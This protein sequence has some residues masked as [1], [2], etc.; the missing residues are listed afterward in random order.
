M[1]IKNTGITIDGKHTLK[2]WHLILESM[3]IGHPKPKTSIINVFGRNGVIDA[4]EYLM[5][6][7]IFENRTLEFKFT[8]NRDI[9]REDWELWRSKLLNAVHG[10]KLKVTLD[11]T[12]SWYYIGRVEIEPDEDDGTALSFTMT[13][14]AEPFQYSDIGQKGNWKWDELC[15]VDG[16]IFLHTFMLQEGTTTIRVPNCRMTV[17]PTITANEAVTVE[18]GGGRYEIQKNTPTVRPAILLRE[19]HN[20][21]KITASKA[22]EVNIDFS[23]GK[24]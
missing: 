20:E 18:Y 4:S 21:F 22:T 9:R 19:G 5:D 3:K 6:L 7:P 24:L 2:D 16:S 13:V 8:F 12:P 23:I 15:F 1:T 10:K 11:C 14:D 17:V